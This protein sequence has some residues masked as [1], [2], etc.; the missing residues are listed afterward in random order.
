V[1]E[2][3][4][5]DP[6]CAAGYWELAYAGTQLQQALGGVRRGRLAP[7]VSR[8]SPPRSGPPGRERVARWARPGHALAAR[9]PSADPAA[10]C[11]PWNAGYAA[12]C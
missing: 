7:S 8:A 5:A 12:P 1:F 10:D 6:Q 3:F 11:S 2:R 4:E 9:Y